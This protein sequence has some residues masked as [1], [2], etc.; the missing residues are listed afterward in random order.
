MV[1]IIFMTKTKYAFNQS[2]GCD[3]ICLQSL[4]AKGLNK[5]AIMITIRILWMQSELKRMLAISFNM[6]AI[7]ENFFRQEIIVT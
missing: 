5:L 4:Y 1:A 7:T 3:L 2:N 6:V